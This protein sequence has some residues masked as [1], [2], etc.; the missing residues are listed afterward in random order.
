M[1]YTIRLTLEAVKDIKR[2]RKSGDKKLLQKIEVLL[3]ELIQHPRTG[4]GKPEL[5]KHGFMEINSIPSQ[6][7]AVPLF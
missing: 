7:L 2:H 4:T 3:E 5:L 6:L 1:N